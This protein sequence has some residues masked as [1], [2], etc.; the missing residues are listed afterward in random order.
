M[1][2]ILALAGPTGIGKS[3]VALALAAEIPAEIVAV[4]SMQVYRGMDIGTGKPAKEIRRRV[5]HH[6]IDL[7]EPE[8]EFDVLRYV[9][10]VSPAIE[11]IRRG[12]RWAILTAGCGL[13]L[14][15]LLRGICDAPGKDPEVRGRLLEEAASQGSEALHARLAGVDPQ[16]A[17]RIHPND[18]RRVVRA[19]EVFEVTGRPMTSWWAEKERNSAALGDYRIIGLTCDRDPL[20]SRVEARIDSWLAAG[21]LEEARALAQRDLGITAREA[22]GYRELFNHLQGRSDWAATRLLIHRNT[23]RYAKRQLSWFRHEPGVRWVDVQGL[24]PRLVA[25]EILAQAPAVAQKRM[26]AFPLT[27]AA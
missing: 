23:R 9:E 20:Y 17:A 4:D 12:G 22:L 7:A 1:S 26:A 27:P 8:E 3:E 24:D 19:L 13:Y 2:G 25:Q 10:A 6:G 11:R 21:W 15:V 16:A 18:L 5:P 14:R